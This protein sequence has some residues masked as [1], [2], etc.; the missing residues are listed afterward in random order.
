MAALTGYRRIDGSVGVRN[1]VLVLSNVTCANSVVEQ[2]GW[3]L[4]KEVVALPHIYGCGQGGA[5]LEQT[6][7]TLLGTAKHPNVA[8]VL[9]VSLGCETSNPDTLV[10]E[11]ASTGKIV[12]LIRIQ[13]EGGTRK[14]FQKG[15]KIARQMIAAARF[16]Q[17]I[18]IDLSE[19]CFGVECG[20]SDGYSGISANVAIGAVADRVVKAGGTVILSEVPE[21][22]G[23]EELLSPRTRDAATCTR[24]LTAISSWHEQAKLNGID[25]M[26]AQIQPGNWEGGLTTP[27]EKSLGAVLKGGSSTINEFIEYAQ[28][29]SQ[30]GLVIMNTAGDDIESMV[31]MVAGGAH[32]ILFSTGRGTPTGHPITPVFKIAS[33]TALYRCMKWNL[34]YNAGSILTGKETVME[35]EN[36]I[37]NLLVDVVNGNLT[38]SERERNHEFAIQ[39]IGPR[40]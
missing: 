1:H 37:F 3:A 15:V 6:R 36:H 34:D 38:R 20:G 16:D 9:L 30:K 4:R 7:R 25:L 21:M 26:G 35:A 8:S 40:I 29:P 27:E 18:P 2:I 23:S 19:L 31:G 39:I 12:E 28:R 17:R 33:N 14:S 11:I 13:A 22:I 10:Q 5:D 24:L 32:I